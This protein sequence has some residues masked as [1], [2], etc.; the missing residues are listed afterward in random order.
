[1]T[2]F[3]SEVPDPLQLHLDETLFLIESNGLWKKNQ[4]R[5]KLKTMA[6]RFKRRQNKTALWKN[7]LFE[8]ESCV[9]ATSHMAS[10][11]DDGVVG[12]LPC[13]QGGSLD[14]TE[15]LTGADLHT[16]N[17]ALS[18]ASLYMWN[19]PQ[20]AGFC[21]TFVSYISVNHQMV[22]SLWCVFR[23]FQ[24]FFYILCVF[25]LFFFSSLWELEMRLA[26]VCLQSHNGNRLIHLF[27]Y[28]LFLYSPLFTWTIIKWLQRC[29][30]VFSRH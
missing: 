14:E 16:T 8:L 27:S 17:S 24:S 11:P 28:L 20:T 25:S 10:F 12:F 23:Y 6:D 19:L 2:I 18:V 4:R 21:Q 13:Y 3:F 30:R 1:M 22:K 5:E 15:S 7:D 26:I 9:G 29:S